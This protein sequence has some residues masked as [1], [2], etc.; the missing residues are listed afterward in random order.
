VIHYDFNILFGIS[1][2]NI[3]GIDEK[4]LKT[5]LRIEGVCDE[6]AEL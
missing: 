6:L 2:A 1:L 4:R 5:E 3:F